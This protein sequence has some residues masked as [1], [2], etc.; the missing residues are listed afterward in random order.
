MLIDQHFD[1][2]HFPITSNQ[3]LYLYYL[4]DDLR[5]EVV[6][7]GLLGDVVLDVAHEEPLHRF[8]NTRLVTTVEFVRPL[9]HALVDHFVFTSKIAAV[10]PTID[11]ALVVDED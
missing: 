3:L 7:D 11:V 5:G 1:T 9:R 8:V 2:L 10:I 6:L 4:I